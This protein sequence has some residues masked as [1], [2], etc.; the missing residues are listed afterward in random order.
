MRS[1]SADPTAARSVLLHRPVLGEH[2]WR[3]LTCSPLPIGR[4][5][6]QERGAVPPQS[7]VVRK[8]LS[9]VTS[10]SRPTGTAPSLSPL[11]AKGLHQK[12]EFY[13]SKKSN[14]CGGSSA[15][16]EYCKKMSQMQ[17]MR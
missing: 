2:R 4:H 17:Q 7:P 8:A 9:P 16:P 5:F 13:E 14:D 6:R 1:G 11:Y 3:A 15:A 10:L 12:A